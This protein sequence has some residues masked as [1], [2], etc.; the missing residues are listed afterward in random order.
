MVCERERVI[1]LAH[2]HSSIGRCSVRAVMV[3]MCPFSLSHT[4]VCSL[5]L[6]LSLSL[7]RARMHTSTHISWA[8]DP[9]PTQAASTGADR[10]SSRCSPGKTST[11][12]TC[13]CTC[14]SRGSKHHAD[15]PPPYGSRILAITDPLVK[16]NGF[17]A[18]HQ[19]AT[20]ATHAACGVGTR[21]WTTTARTMLTPL[22]H[23]DSEFH[24]FLSQA[25][26][27]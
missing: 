15:N 27:V 18:K 8:Y 22:L 12:N 26:R 2:V 19:R 6:S 20:R 13:T 24:R 3:Y 1:T 9:S 5:F 25:R 21:M 14:A 10:T 23:T 11:N 17:M 16:D 7:L 4:S